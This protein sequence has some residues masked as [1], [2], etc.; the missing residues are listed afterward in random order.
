[1]RHLPTILLSFI[2]TML[3]LAAQSLSIQS[4]DGQIVLENFRATSSMKVRA[5]DPLGR[6]L[7][8][9]RIEWTVTTGQGELLEVTTSTDADGAAQ[10]F[11]RATVVP[12]GMSVQPSTV[13]ARSSFGEVRFRVTTALVSFRG[14]LAS[15]PIVQLVS[16]TLDG[17]VPTGATGSTLTGAVVVRVGISGGPDV[18]QPLPNVGIRVQPSGDIAQGPS[19]VCRGANGIILTDERGLAVCDLVLNNRTGLARLAVNAGE[20]VTTRDFLVNIVS[21]T[22]CVFSIQP[23]IKPISA[24]GGRDSFFLSA[25]GLSC[26]WAVQSNVSWLSVVSAASGTGP[27]EIFFSAESNPSVNQRIGSITVGGQ[28]L[29]ISQSGSGSTGVLTITTPTTLPIA[30]AGQPISYPLQAQGG[31]LPYRWSTGVGSALPA[32]FALSTEGI[33]TGVSPSPGTATFTVTAV[34]AVGTLASKGLQ[35][36][37]LP[38]D[39]NQNPSFLTTSFASGATG[40]PYRQSI[41]VRVGCANLVSSTLRLE[42]T[43]G[44][45]PAGLEL[46]QAG[47]QWVIQGTPTEAGRITAFALRATNPCGLTT[48]ADF[49]ITIAGQ[50]GGGTTTSQ[51]SSLP[52]SLNFEVFQGRATAVAPQ[53]LTVRSTPSVTYSAAP[54]TGWITIASGNVGLTNTTEMTVGIANFESFGPGQYSGTILVS[55]VGV[56]SL[57]IPVTLTVNPPPTLFVSPTGLTFSVPI[58]IAPVPSGTIR[59]TLSVSGGVGTVFSATGQTSGANWLRVTP[60]ISTSP[61]VLDVEIN[62]VGLSPGNYSGR[63][64]IAVGGAIVSTIPVN[65][66]VNNPPQLIWST[67]ALTFALTP[68]DST[69]R[70]QTL[71]LSTTSSSPS[72]VSITAN[73]LNGGNWLRVDQSSGTTPMNVVV[74]VDTSGLSAGQYNGEILA[75]AVDGSTLATAGV[76]VLLL[77]T[78]TNPTIQAVVN[79]ASELQGPLTPGAWAVVHGTFLGSTGTPTPYKVTIGRVDTTLSDV[80][81]LVDGLPAPILSASSQRTVF[82]VPYSAADRQRISVVVEYKG[83]RSQPFDVPI[84]FVNP[85][86]FVVGATQ[87]DITNEDGSKNSISRPADVGETVTIFATGEGPTDP[88][89]VDGLIIGND[90]VPKPTVLPVQV[91]MDGQEAEVVSFG[92]VPGMPAGLFQVKAKIPATVTRGIPVA[93]TIGVNSNYTPDFVTVAIKP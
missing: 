16:P 24:S 78:E 66:T 21:G 75:R 48:T 25:T 88:V 40:Q 33:L 59:Q 42:R 67:S 10:A 61:A 68:G 80:R 12:G 5:I 86:I 17:P 9:A 69:L 70:P 20:F 27:A 39:A 56:A 29:T 1:M 23:T 45:L 89:G 85:A 28:S 15:P 41:E 58:A 35:L 92:A 43:A 4:G 65:L 2:G 52:T 71:A 74:S 82:Q 87:G 79:A 32:G 47:A 14:T 8:G 57:Q 13:L 46:V 51:L 36:T 62:H 26:G 81:I 22:P 37:V 53:R 64:V 93:V 31:R 54:A 77:I 76:R 55:A 72:R 3:P 50:G 6:P 60:S 38:L 11:F 63:V 7:V 34:D 44:T 18:G 19:A 49:T 90:N 30:V 91:W 83:N 84:V 73:I